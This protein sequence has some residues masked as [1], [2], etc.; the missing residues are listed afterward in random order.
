[1]KNMKSVRIFAA[2]LAI[3]ASAAATQA[4]EQKPIPSRVTE[5]TVFLQGAEVTHTASATLKKGAGEISIEGLSPNIDRNSLKINIGGSVVVS[6]FEFSIDHLSSAKT[7]PARLKML[8][9]S[10]KIYQAQLDRVDVDIK[11]NSG[12]QGYL[13]TGI[14][15]N[16]SGSEAGLGIDELRKTMD[17]YKAKS[18]EILNGARELQQKR[19]KVAGALTRI[20]NQYNEE[21]GSSGKTSGVLRLNLTAPAAGTYPV[22]ISYYTP[23]A[24]W[25]PYYDIN[26]ASTDGPVKISARSHVSQTT[27]LDWENV[28]LTLSTATPGGGKVAPL[29][30]TWFLREIVPVSRALAGRVAGIAVQNAYSYDM[31]E[32][33]VLEDAVVTA[34]QEAAPAPTIYDFVTTADNAVSVVYNID[35]PYSI[36]GNGKQQNID[37]AVKETPAVYKYY[38]APKLDG[39]TYL[40]AEISE[41]EKL[42]LLSAP[43]NITYDGTYIG[44]TYIDAAATQEKLTLTLGTDKRVNVTRELVREFNAPK[45]VGSN[46][47]QTFTWKLTVRNSRTTPVYMMLKDQYPVSTDKSVIVTLDTKTTTPWTANKEDVG[48]VTWEGEMAAG[49]VRIHTFSYTVKYPREKRLNL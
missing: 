7:P 27:G 46:T 45:T 6:A 29:F 17:Y 5:A 36:P 48:V 8:Q 44:E 12:M 38:C 11:V 30:S 13:E 43:A 18:E 47:E 26:V 15:K 24:G 35:L 33:A 4:Q 3:M 2:A 34:K 37:L 21:S 16:V 10:M 1:M 19:Q 31:A 39:A 32:E 23:S 41:W 40:I 49:E 42:G 20:R 25:S 14:A 22:T 9:D 28:R